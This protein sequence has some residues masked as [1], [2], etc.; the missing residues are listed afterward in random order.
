MM[1]DKRIGND[2]IDMDINTIYWNRN[3]DELFLLDYGIYTKYART[4]EISHNNYK[5]FL[6]P[7]L[8]T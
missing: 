1:Y 6:S 3:T 5:C 2:D 8:L 7:E 4:N